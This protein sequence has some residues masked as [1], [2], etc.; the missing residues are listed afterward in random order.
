MQMEELRVGAMDCRAIV[1]SATVEAAIILLH[2]YA[3]DVE[4]IAPL[5]VAMRLPAALYFPRGLLDATP[6]GRSWWALD[7]ERRSTALALG[8]RD[9][10]NEYPPS[11]E[12]ARHALL[13]AIEAVRQR[14]PSVPLILA[15][16]SQGG[17][18]ACD[19]LL[20]ETAQ[21]AG[22]ILMSTS[23]IAID[24]WQPR[25]HR[26]RK[27]PVL[28]S[29]GRND[30][31]LSLQAGEQLRDSLMA[32]G[33]DVTWFAFDGGHEIPLTVW[34][35]FKRMVTHVARRQNAY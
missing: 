16:F 5:A 31:D 27:L 29:H 34:R 28:I 14:H 22:L 17:M 19:T 24:D 6:R 25:L 11:R 18:L 12:I 2:G 23:R 7:E 13:G 10:S 26:L 3:M 35:Q 8:P 1:P 20:H 15:G 9:L 32:A 21:V 30:P 4:D 33:A